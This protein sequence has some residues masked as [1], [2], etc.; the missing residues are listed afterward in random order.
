M[1]P[2]TFD[3]LNPSPNAPALP[4][5]SVVAQRSAPGAAARPPASQDSANV[6]NFVSQAGFTS[7]DKGASS[8]AASG[9]AA[10]QPQGRRMLSEVRTAP[11][12]CYC[13]NCRYFWLC[14]K[15]R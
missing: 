9:A 15:V 6:R 12:H 10:A 1:R 11:A 7:A 13:W 3:W 2:Q 8:T 5:D 4:A 14:A